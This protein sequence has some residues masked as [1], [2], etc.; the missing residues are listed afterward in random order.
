MTEEIIL[1]DT[2]SSAMLCNAITRVDV[3]HLQAVHESRVEIFRDSLTGNGV[4]FLLQVY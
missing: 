3:T 1:C 4:N 2:M